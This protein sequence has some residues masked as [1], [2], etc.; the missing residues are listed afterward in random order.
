M[1]KGSG[2]DFEPAVVDALA[3]AVQDGS[4]ELNLPEVALPAGIKPT[5]PIS[6]AGLNF[7]TQPR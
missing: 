3:R 5:Q 2:T 7:S 6:I 1:K 4:L